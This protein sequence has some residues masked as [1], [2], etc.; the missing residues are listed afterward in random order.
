MYLLIIL[1]FVGALSHTSDCSSEKDSIE[2]LRLCVIELEKNI[3]SEDFADLALS[4][5]QDALNQMR[6]ELTVAYKR[7]DVNRYPAW[8]AEVAGN[9][10]DKL[11]NEIRESPENQD[12]RYELIEKLTSLLKRAERIRGSIEDK[13]DGT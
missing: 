2:K 11:L 7:G 10:I 3:D 5:V 12:L 4:D 8:R 1:G 9:K 13:A 6:D